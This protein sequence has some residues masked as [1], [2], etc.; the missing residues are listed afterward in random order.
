MPA[1][2]KVHHE[3]GKK[4]ILPYV[5]TKNEP[6]LH[7]SVK[8]T[9][10]KELRCFIITRTITECNRRFRGEY[11]HGRR[12][13]RGFMISPNGA[14]FEGWFRDDLP[15]GDGILTWPDG[16]KFIGK[17]V[18]GKVNTPNIACC[19][20]ELDGSAAIRPLTLG[21]PRCCLAVISHR[22][23]YGI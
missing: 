8:Q 10:E 5:R 12:H 19:L 1:N 23:M 7:F 18:A 2:N 11:R 3:T 13:G 22:L 9:R 16:G 15:D 17:Y 14:R 6:G 4:R 21:R 20:P